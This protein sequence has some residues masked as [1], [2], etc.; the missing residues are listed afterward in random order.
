MG[1]RGVSI[2]MLVRETRISYWL[3]G[4]LREVAMP[5]ENSGLPFR[6]SNAW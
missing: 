5:I 6:V 2:R 3:S 4:N 1:G